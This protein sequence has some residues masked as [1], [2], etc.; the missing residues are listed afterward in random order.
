MGGHHERA[1]RGDDVEQRLDD[2]LRAAR[3]PA[4]RLE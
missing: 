1:A 4:Q 2:G 3:D